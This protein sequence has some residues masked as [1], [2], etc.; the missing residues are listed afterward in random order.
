MYVI[1]Y[2]DLAQGRLPPCHYL[3]PHIF[4]CF[5]LFVVPPTRI[6]LERS[7]YFVSE[8]SVNISCSTFGSNPQAYT[9]IWHEGKE[10]PILETRAISPLES[11]IKAK[12]LPTQEDDGS[13]LVC[14]AENPLITSS[15][16]EDQWKIDVRYAPK[17][18]Y[19]G[20]QRIFGAI[21]EKILLLCDVSPFPEEKNLEFTWKFSSDGGSK[22][23]SLDL[24]TSVVDQ[25]TDKLHYY[26]ES[27][28]AFG[29]V[30]CTARS[31]M[32][33]FED[34]SLKGTEKPC[35]FEI[36]PKGTIYV[37]QSKQDMIYLHFFQTCLTWMH[38]VF[39]N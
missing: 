12:F 26:L 39:L 5:L 30:V 1:L 6:E 32:G 28:K 9:R 35:I 17:C 14:R 8:K 20:P 38:A 2:L 7:P 21:G 13:F 23:S 22:K 10:L 19:K 11:V 31:L 4:F 3:R 25:M 15:A 16:V 24:R 33:K 27:E 34:E 29:K 37:C 18:S 36:V